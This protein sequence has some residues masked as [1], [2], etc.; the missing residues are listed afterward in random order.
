MPIKVKRLLRELKEG[1][2]RIYGDRL[3][4]LYLYGSY[5]RG[6]AQAESDVD[7]MIV[8]DDYE[9][10]GQEIDR[11]GGL[12]SELSLEYGISISRV[13]VKES[14]WLNRET[15][16]LGNIHLDGIPA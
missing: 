10:Y 6:D 9:S 14:Q 7:V 3:K 13:I 12:I 1:L 8:L 5:A 2:G 15:P 4:G 11:T 16:L